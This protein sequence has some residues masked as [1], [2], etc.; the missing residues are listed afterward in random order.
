MNSLTCDTHHKLCKLD[1]FSVIDDFSLRKPIE[2]RT[3]ETIK[4]IVFII[5]LFSTCTIG[6]AYRNL[7]QKKSVLLEV[8]K[9]Q[10]TRGRVC[11]R[12]FLEIYT[13]KYAHACFKTQGHKH[14]LLII[15]VRI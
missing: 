14:F 1:R 3:L 10:K 7:A 6:T 15:F 9:N 13:M 12:K 8:K 4:F 5:E 11:F 2:K